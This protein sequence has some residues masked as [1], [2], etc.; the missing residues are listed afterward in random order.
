MSSLNIKDTGVQDP[1]NMGKHWFG[2]VWCVIMG[3]LVNTLIHSL[4]RLVDSDCNPDTDWFTSVANPI[5]TL[6]V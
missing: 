4:T 2:L 6:V 3:R 1:T 5:L